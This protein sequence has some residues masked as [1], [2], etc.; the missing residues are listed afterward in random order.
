MFPVYTPLFERGKFRSRTLLFGK[1][2]G[3]DFWVE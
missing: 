2:G 1:R 3:G